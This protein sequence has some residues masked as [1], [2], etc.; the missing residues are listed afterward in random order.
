MELHYRIFAAE[1]LL[2]F[3]YTLTTLL[4]KIL[5]LE[6]RNEDINYGPTMYLYFD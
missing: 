3:I 5:E 6:K 4:T 2:S 1:W